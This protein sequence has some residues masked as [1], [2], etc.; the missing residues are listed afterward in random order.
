[1]RRLDAGG[2]L[3]GVLP[4]HE[5]YN[6][7]AEHAAT[8]GSSRTPNIIKNAFEHLSKAP[9]TTAG[10][11]GADGAEDGSGAMCTITRHGRTALVPWTWLTVA[12]ALKVG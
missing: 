10:G 3:L 11:A 8:L 9:S 2:G 7:M 6:P 5:L 4:L 1:M 12:L